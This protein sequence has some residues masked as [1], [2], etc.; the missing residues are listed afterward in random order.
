MGGGISIH[1][2]R[3]RRRLFPKETKKKKEHHTLA[4][5]LVPHQRFTRRCRPC[6]FFSSQ[7][8]RIVTCTHRTA[9]A[10]TAAQLLDPPHLD[11]LHHAAVPDDSTPA[12]SAQRPAADAA[13]ARPAGH[14]S[15]F[16]L[17]PAQSLGR[18]EAQVHDALDDA[19][20]DD[21]ADGNAENVRGG[22][23]AA[24]RLDVEEGVGVEALCVVRDV[25]EG[26]VQCKDDDEPPCVDPGRGRGARQDDL[27]E[28]EDA[29]EGVLGGVAECVK[30]GGE[31]DARVDDAPVDGGDDEGVDGD[32]GVV[33]GVEG[34]E[35]A[36]EAV[37]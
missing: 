33:E 20:H 12:P 7:A 25:R 14:S 28:G 4:K 5:L 29:V 30:G 27:D 10:S 15:E 9:L 18:P 21:G 2:V 24:L 37:E 23:G 6:T 31:P 17:A 22:D 19:K 1:K 3:S 35:R 34:L 13:A 36:R 32:G 11:V 16:A 26:E 8:P